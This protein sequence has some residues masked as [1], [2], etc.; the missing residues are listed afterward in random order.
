MTERFVTVFSNSCKS[1]YPE[2]TMANFKNSLFIPLNF[3]GDWQVS[4]TQISFPFKCYNVEPQR[5]GFLASIRN[6]EM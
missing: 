1:I 4:L 6:N 2:N 5:I 3:D